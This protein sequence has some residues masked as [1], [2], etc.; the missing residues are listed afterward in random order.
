[1]FVGPALLPGRTLSNSDSLYFTAPWTASRPADLQRP[2]QVADEADWNLLFEPY[3]RYNR[4]ELPGIPLWNPY[5][6]SGRPW[7]GNAQSAVFSPLMLPALVLPLGV[8]SG[9][10]VA[11]KLFAAALGMFLLA[12]SMGLR[13]TGAFV[14]G[15]VFAYAMPL[16]SYLLEANVT[17]VWA[18]LPWLL[19]STRLVVTRRGALPVCGLAAIAAAVFL[20]GHPETIAQ[21][22]AGATAFLILALLRKPR[23]R[24]HRTAG[25]ALDVGRFAAG[26]LWGAAL[27]AVA[28]APFVELLMHS[29][30]LAERGVAVHRELP[31]S[32]FSTLFMPDYW[33]RGTSLT[34][35]AQG[36]GRFLYFGALPLLLALV[37]L[38]RPTVE[39]VACAVFAI[40]CTAVAFGLFPFAD[41]ANALPG[42]SKT[43]N[44]RLIV[45]GLPALALL[46]GWGLDDLRGDGGGPPSRPRGADPRR[47]PAVRAPGLAGRRSSAALRAGAG[48]R[49]SPGALARPASVDV[50]RLASLVLWLTMAGLA[51]RSWR[52]ASAAGCVLR[53]VRGA[54]DRPR[55]RGPLPR[56]DGLQPGD[57]ARPRD[58]AGDGRDPL[59]AVAP[60]GALRRTRGSDAR[61]SRHALPPLR[62]PRLRLPDRASLPPPVGGGGQSRARPS[63]PASRHPLLVQPGHARESPDPRASRA[64]RT[65]WCRRARRRR[66]ARGT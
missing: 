27:A 51:A 44:T 61:R 22:F 55:G 42:L 49:G 9:L 58:A 26:V 52:Y 3:L 32:Y 28:I 23:E 64:W 6:M 24:G 8:A 53:R 19:I 2:S 33:G 63:S 25:W 11:L 41:V 65:S 48:A 40:A 30:D 36:L 4:E 5:L 29:S 14:A 12:R 13:W 47:R 54:R 17:A 45:I 7:I 39:R 18:L 43:D 66:C 21:V 16:V 60:P 62:R 1:M 31:G 46:A 56:R 15:L 38:L 59:P 35:N 10:V 57:R 50:M 34:I 20:G 37:A